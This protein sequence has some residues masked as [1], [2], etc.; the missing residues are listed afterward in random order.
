MLRGKSV[1]RAVSGR[2]PPAGAHVRGHLHDLMTWMGHAPVESVGGK[3]ALV[4]RHLRRRLFEEV[5]AEA[6]QGVPFVDHHLWMYHG[7]R[8]SITVGECA[9]PREKQDARHRGGEAG[10][11]QGRKAARQDSA[12]QW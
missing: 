5:R 3:P 4:L 8:V 6:H 10:R 1:D 11:G 2:E 9:R 7:I 12:Q